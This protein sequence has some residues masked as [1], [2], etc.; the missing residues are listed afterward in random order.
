MEYNCPE[1]NGKP[2]VKN[3]MYSI[4]LQFSII[5]FLSMYFPSFIHFNEKQTY[6]DQ[7]Y[8]F[9]NGPNAFVYINAYSLSLQLLL[10]YLLLWPQ[11]M[12]IGHS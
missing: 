7:I 2:K 5:V 10:L 6:C 12:T 3:S 8:Y 11:Q 4:I 1:L 9:F